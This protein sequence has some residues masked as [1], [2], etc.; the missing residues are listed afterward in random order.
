VFFIIEALNG[1]VY[2]DA[3][4]QYNLIAELGGVAQIV[5]SPYDTAWIHYVDDSEKYGYYPDYNA[6]AVKFRN[7][8]TI[9]MSEGT[10][11]KC[12][13]DGEVAEVSTS[14]DNAPYIIVRSKLELPDGEDESAQ[15]V[16]LKVKYGGLKGITVN[17]GDEVLAGDVIGQ[18]GANGLYMHLIS[19]R[20]LEGIHYYYN[21]FIFVDRLYSTYYP[22]GGLL[23]NEYPPG[24][25]LP[26]YGETPPEL[27]AAFLAKYLDEA[28]NYIGTPYPSNPDGSLW[29]NP[30]V[31]MSCA[32]FVS[33]VLQ[34][35]GYNNGQFISQSS[36]YLYQGY[37]VPIIESEAMPGDLVFFH[38][39]YAAAYGRIS[40]VGIYLG[41]GKMVHNGS[42]NAII[43]LFTS[44]L[45]NN[46]FYTFARLKNY[47]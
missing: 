1:F 26:I 37:C 10:D 16:K 46:K 19:D 7:S 24:L 32:A 42:P 36:T 30:P 9:H 18:T 2:D 8:I 12:G 20:V 29:S 6:G 31:T 13:V 15:N 3:V 27:P 38:S 34:Q 21:P 28:D 43:D 41:N 44:N 17:V 40:H 35:S 5:E 25:G 45:Y 23:P 33:Y 22:I 47:T 11:V 39:T 14:G 4:E